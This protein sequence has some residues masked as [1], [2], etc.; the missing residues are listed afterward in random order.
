M[1]IIGVTGTNGAGKNAVVDFLVSQKGFTHYSMRNFLVEEIRKRGMPETR[2]VM[3]A[4]GNE[5]REKFGPGYLVEQYLVRARA[6]SNPVVIES[7]RT[8]GEIEALKKEP[9]ALLL[10]VDAPQ[11]LRY[12]RVVTRKSSTDAISFEQFVQDEEKESRGVGMGIQNLPKCIELA[13]VVIINE[14][15]L[16]ELWGKV[17]AILRR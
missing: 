3:F 12:E 6:Q 2:D 14:G 13:D 8:L 7:I 11:T 15:T 5:L 16:E 9:Q 17:E 1:I 4:L 10:A